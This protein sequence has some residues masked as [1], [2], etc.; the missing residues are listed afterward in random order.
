MKRKILYMCT[1]GLFACN[2][3]QSVNNKIS[4]DTAIK[5]A[6]RK[7]D[8]N[9]LIDSAKFLLNDAN[10]YMEKGVKKQMLPSKVNAKVKPLMEQY[11]AVYKQLR[12]VDTVVVYNYR[13]DLLNK[14]IDLQVKQD[15]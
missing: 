12:P 4:K 10:F 2:T 5:V 13:I 14:L 11:F 7:T 8:Y 1:L 3:S 6:V 9:V 15:Q